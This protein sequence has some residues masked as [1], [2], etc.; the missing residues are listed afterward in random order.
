MKEDT[1]MSAFTNMDLG[2]RI[3][4]LRTKK[5]MSQSELAD[6]VQTT[7]TTVSKWEN[8]DSEPSASQLK[9][10]ADTFG[11]S[12][13]YLCG[14]MDSI[15][16][17]IC[18]LDTCIILNRPRA[19][20]LL[21][22]SK[23]YSKIVVPDVVVQE[24]NYQKDHAKGSMK[25]RAW[26]SM[27]TVENNKSSISID[28]T[29]FNKNEVNDDRI[30]AVA[31]N[32]ALASANNKVDILTNDVYFSL[33]YQT[34]GIKNLFIKSFNDVE[35]LLHKEDDFDEFNTQKFISEVKSKVLSCVKN[36]YNSTVNINRIDPQTGFT[37]LIQAVRDRSYDIIEYLL[38][39]D[40][41][42][43]EKRDEFKYAFTPLLHCCQLKDTKSMNLL[44]NNGASVNAS[45]RG[46]NKGNTPLMVC[47]WGQFNDG[48]K[49]LMENSDLSFNQQDNNGFTALHKACYRNNF[50]GIRL[51][52]D[53]I[54][55]NIEDFNNKKAVELLDKH[56]S[57]FEKIS[58]LFRK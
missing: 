43:I 26:L 10:I 41:I 22:K 9:M 55:N 11:V 47:A 53:K 52:I 6:L 16:E 58:G 50:D 46:K 57:Q 34:F 44:I 23:L 56:S 14:N 21:I 51:L 35:A 42:D 19:I 29:I 1:R 7:R 30:M 25:Q 48:I 24:L 49:L 27:V 33:K 37:P 3:L 28:K 5:K 31:K 40:G 17:A 15:G 4:G 8:G 38:S 39:L 32:Y 13:D 18:V 54:D 2:K 45:S 36:A 20:D 12:I